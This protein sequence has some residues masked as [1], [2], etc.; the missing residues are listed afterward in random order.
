MIIK[1]LVIQLAL[2]VGLLGPGQV[3]FGSPIPPD[4]SVFTNIGIDLPANHLD[5]TSS[6]S[7]TASLTVSGAPAGATVTDATATGFPLT[8][9]LAQFGDGASIT[10]LTSGSDPDALSSLTLNFLFE[11]KNLSADKLFE[12]TFGVGFGLDAAAKGDNA[13]AQASFG[14]TAPDAIPIDWYAPA[15]GSFGPPSGGFTETT[16]VLI[17][18]NPRQT[19]TFTGLLDVYGT[20]KFTGPGV[21]DDNYSAEATADIRIGGVTTRAVSEPAPITLFAVL[22]LFAAFRHRLGRWARKASAAHP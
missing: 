7:A 19:L 10:V 21:T 9:T 5:G 2:I 17:T 8:G 15:D 13:L 20:T 16:S 18:I 14:I 3:A 4:L 6:R 12:I 22:P 11:I 1:T